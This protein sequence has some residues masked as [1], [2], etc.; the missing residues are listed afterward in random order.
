MS[1]TII[2]CRRISNS[3][4]DRDLVP[5]DL[6]LDLKNKIKNTDI[7]EIFFTSGFGKNNAFRLFYVDILGLRITK[8]IRKRRGIILPKEFL[9]KEVKLTVLYS[10]SKTANLGLST[11]K[12]YLSNKSKFA[13]SKRPVHDFKVWYYKQM[14]SQ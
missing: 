6:N 10:P 5:I 12:L 7:K 4:L 2:R 9:G 1:D 11:S 14:F 3:A 13:D 8:E